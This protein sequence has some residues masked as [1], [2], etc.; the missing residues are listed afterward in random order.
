MAVNYLL[1]HGER[2]MSKVEPPG[3]EDVEKK[4]V[5]SYAAA[6]QRFLERIPSVTSAL[7]AL[8]D[9]ACPRDEAVSLL[10]IHPT[11]LAKSH[12]PAHLLRAT[13]LRSIGSRERLLIPSVP[14][15]SIAT[16]STETAA[17]LFVAGDRKLIAALETEIGRW[18][19]TSKAAE[20]LRKV[21]D[22]RAPSSKRKVRVAEYDDK[23]NYWEVVLHA[24]PDAAGKEVL[25][26]FTEFVKHY[27]GQAD[28]DRRMYAGNLCFLPVAVEFEESENVADFVFLR[29]MRSMSRL[30]PITRIIGSP[31][32][33]DCSLPSVPA[34][35]S[36]IR[37]AILDGGPVVGLDRWV[38]NIEA[39][40]IGTG[41]VDDFKDHSL[42]VSSAYLFGPIRDGEPLPQPYSNVDVIQVLDDNI[43][44]PD[45]FDVLRRIEDEMSERDYDFVGISLG[46]DWP[47]EDDEPHAWGAVLDKCFRD[48]HVM[49]FYVV[50]NNGE[51]DWESG[52]A[53]VQSPADC[54]N[55]FAFGSCTSPT[56]PVS[57]SK[58]SSIGPGRRP[59]VVR[60]E[61]VA[62]GG[63]PGN[64]Y[65]VVGPAQG[66]A[67]PVLGTSFA[68]PTGMRIGVGVRAHLGPIVS[69]LAIKALMINRVDSGEDVSMREV[70]WGRIC[71]SAE[72]MLTSDDSTAH[73]IYQRDLSPGSWMRTP[74]PVP[75]GE[76]IGDL[77]LTFTLCYKTDTDPEHS[78]NYTRAGLEAIFRP[79]AKKRREPEQ[80]NADSRPFLTQKRMYGD[81]A[82]EA[83]LRSDSHKW[84]T[85]LHANGTL[86]AKSVYEP[87]LDIHY[88]AREGG[89]NTSAAG[90]IQFALVV[91]VHSKKDKDLY[92][93]IARKYRT[94]L[95]ALT[96]IR[97]P[98]TRI[99]G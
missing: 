64:P 39:S 62:F 66:T 71:H 65:F 42:G 7:N 22:L 79:N 53:R 36:Q 77:F 98:A 33:F 57:R 75:D 84:E 48:K 6:K 41:E 9:S 89:A 21:E 76:L 55:G 34:M 4:Q 72:E 51:K 17:E 43:D 38:T 19:S 83:Q 70:G 27:G 2:L 10:T 96:P 37:V 94:V 68:G 61:A 50:G 91:T 28:A 93:K 23:K 20:D 59:G 95:E 58:H 3:R 78:V 44:G 16:G 60:P 85:V 99:T 90:P 40:G 88:N 47:V 8:P 18:A 26:A 69:P 87:C 73:V 13:Q 1:G 52:N 31:L 82:T 35:D 14:S 11:F 12:F 15:P 56:G 81:F 5:Y 46:P 29:V 25:E 24:G 63:T 92:N 49:P 86:R 30:R 54:V 45:Y 32:T 67:V 97:I 80:R 74:I